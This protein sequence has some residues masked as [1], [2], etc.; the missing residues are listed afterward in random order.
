[1]QAILICSAER[2]PPPLDHGFITQ[3]V[4]WN[5]SCMVG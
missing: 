5:F 3:A 4:R 2:L 1:V